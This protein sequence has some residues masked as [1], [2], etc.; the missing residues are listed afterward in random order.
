MTYDAD[1]RV[2]YTTALGQMYVGDSLCLLDQLEE[3]SVSLFMTSPPFAL[4]RQKEYGN[5]EEHNY[6]AWFRK[7]A[8]KM[9][10]K[11][12][13]DGSLV[14]DLGGAWLRGTPTRS[15]Y[16]YRLLIELVDEC[17][18]HLAEDF[19]W[20]NR[21]KLPGP[22]QWV[23]VDRVRVK[24]AVNNIWWLSK[25][26]TPKADNRNVLKPYTKKMLRM[27]ETGRYNA[28]ARP[29]QH[30]I[31]KT[32]AQ[33]RGGA[34]PPNVIETGYDEPAGWLPD[35]VLDFANTGSSDGYHRFCRANEILQ[36]PARFPRE[37]PDF[38]IRFLTDPDD[39]VVDPFGGSNV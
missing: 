24:D 10:A 3:G 7:F 26:P 12:T 23:N 32:W 37:V 38:F 1:P 36:H 34:I 29:S 5:E 27:I 16:Q 15:L 8:E 28:G 20:F 11:L 33:D 13:D 21:A 14:V 2:V 39:L 22:M 4:T 31:G 25:S 17:G 19:I 35:N 18:Y 6:V 30:Q 9:H